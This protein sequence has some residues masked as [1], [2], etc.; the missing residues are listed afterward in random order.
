LLESPVSGLKY[1][2]RVLRGFQ[3]I[4][5]SDQACGSNL[6]LLFF[7]LGYRPANNETKTQNSFIKNHLNTKMCVKIILFAFV[8]VGNMTDWL[9]LL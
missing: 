8:A 9:N 5:H 4:A 1:L 7:L 2:S 6:Y 3:N